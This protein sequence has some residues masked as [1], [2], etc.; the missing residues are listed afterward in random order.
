MSNKNESTLRASIFSFVGFEGVRTGLIAVH[1]AE[2]ERGRQ[3]IKD[4][5]RRSHRSLKNSTDYAR[6]AARVARTAG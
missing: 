2:A 5:A 1:R 4:E 6:I 3:R